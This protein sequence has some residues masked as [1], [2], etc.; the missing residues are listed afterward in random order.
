MLK[1][2]TKYL[3]F[4]TGKLIAFFKI[5]IVFNKLILWINN[6]VYLSNF[7]N[8][9]KNFLI[10]GRCKLINTKN[11]Q[12]GNNFFSLSNLRIEI[13]ET[14]NYY[15]ELF[16]GNNVTLNYNCHIAC[17]NKILIKDDVLIGSNVLISDHNHTIRH[18]GKFRSG[19]IISNGSIIIE[20]NVW[21]GENVS[22]LGNVNIGKNTIVGCNSVVTKSLKSN[23]IYAGIPAKEIKKL[24]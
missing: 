13:I 6:G 16:I 22:I 23:S 3:M 5:N 19:E 4:S 14:K 20:E 10:D 15:P 12:V 24:K 2:I 7:K 17:C 8:V 11:V 1:E 21:I 18:T 9:G